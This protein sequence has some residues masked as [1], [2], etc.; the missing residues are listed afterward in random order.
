MPISFNFQKRSI[1]RKDIEY[2]M[3][4]YAI[5]NEF[6]LH[7][8]RM[9]IFSFKLEYGTVIVPLFNFHKEINFM[10]LNLLEN[11]SM[12]LYIQWLMLEEKEM[13]T[14]YQEF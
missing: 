3:K 5:E 1:V 13:T 2:Y 10:E 11:I 7:P 14:L 9:L 4:N 6:L 8:Q 12:C